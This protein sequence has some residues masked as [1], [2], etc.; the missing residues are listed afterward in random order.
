MEPLM[1]KRRLDKHMNLFLDLPRELIVNVSLFLQASEVMKLKLT[2]DSLYKLS[3]PLCFS[4]PDERRCSIENF[5]GNPDDVIKIYMCDR[6]FPL[7]FSEI[8][9]IFKNVYH[10]QRAGHRTVHLC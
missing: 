2:T 10:L 3:L 1:K 8:L 7:G 6:K 4:A 9:K 5:I